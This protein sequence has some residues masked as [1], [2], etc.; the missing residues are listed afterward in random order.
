MLLSELTAISPIDGRYG[1]R[2]G[3]LKEIF[4]EYGLIKN[5][6]KVEVLWLR[7]LANHPQILEVPALSNEAQLHL[8]KLVE[9]FSLEMAQRVKEI[10]KTTNHDVKAVEYLIKEHFAGH[11]ELM[12]VSE[13]VH[14]ACT[15]EDINNLAY[16]LML[17]DARE[18]VII[19][20]MNE[21]IT[22]ITQMATDMA[23]I[24]MLS[25]THGQPASP[26]TAGKEFANV[27]YRL[28]RQ[29]K[30]LMDVRILGKINGATGNYNAHLA[31]YPEVNWYELSEQFVNSLGLM[32]NPY[33][34]QIEPHDY[35]AEYFHVMQRF[36]T[37]L[38][39][40]DRDVWGYISNGFFRQKTVAGEIGSSA[41]PHKVNPIDFENSEGNLGLAN[42]IFDHLSQKLPISRWQRD[43]TDSTVLRNLGVGIAHTMISLQATLKGLSKLEV[44]PIAMAAD[45]DRNWE[46][47]AEAIQTVMRRYG[48]EKPYEKLKDLTRGQR[49]NQQ[50]MQDFVDSLEGLPADAKQRLREMTPATYIGNAAQQAAQIELALTLLK[51][52]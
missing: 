11:D 31:A 45:L 35:I 52:R 51:G 20:G 12:A 24:P 19:P 34:I 23:E 21:V 7:M 29:S 43:L 50:I 26:T 8:M 18:F 41:M 17:K 9:A 40:F 32:W 44:D 36:N 37:I 15:S 28:Q 27:A 1:A 22:K 47:L 39:D 49:V 3:N 33:T 25:R 6:V 16:A 42:A 46:V 5:R 13:F 48:F 30:Q 2:L 38:I 14:F 4:S 10:E